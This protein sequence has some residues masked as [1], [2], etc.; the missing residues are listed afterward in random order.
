MTIHFVNLV[1]WSY[2]IDKDLD[3]SI[4]FADS[5]SFCLMARLVG[6]NL[7]QISGVSSAMQICDKI[8][9]GYLLSEDKSI[10]NSFVLPFWKDLN[11]IT[12]D[13]ELLNFISKY[14][15]I[16]ISI[17]S[18][19]QDKLAMLINKIQLNKNIY[20]LGAAININKSVKF[21]EYFNLMW[22]G[23]LFSNPIR[24]FNKIYLTIHSIIT[25]LFSDDIKSNF[26]CV[27]KKINS[28]NYFLK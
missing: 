7:K 1:S 18:P 16:V 19:K 9:T 24:T 22:L 26:I 5:I 6:I 10:P 14:E 3:E 12:L 25:I 28:E 23:F 4:I 13:N 20:C 15:N 17:S 8:S 27:A 11:E 2:F 21:L